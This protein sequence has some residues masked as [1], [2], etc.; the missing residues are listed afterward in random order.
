MSMSIFSRSS[1]FR[2][3][4]RRGQFY[5]IEA[6]LKVQADGQTGGQLVGSS[7]KL[8][9]AL[10][11]YNLAYRALCGILF[12][13]VPKSGHPGGSIS[14]GHIIAGLLFNTMD[15][16]IGDPGRKDADHLCFAAGHKAMGL[17]AAWALRNECVRISMK[18]LLPVSENQQL[19]L[20]DLLGFRRNPASKTPLFKKYNSK[21][22]D[23]HPSPVTP[24]VRL[25]TGASGVGVTTAVGMALGVLD[26]YYTSGSSSFAVPIIH[27]LEGEGGLTPGRVQE[28]MAAA[29]SAQLKNIIMHIDWN[30]ASIDSNR[31]C[32]EGDLA[33]DYV[34][35]SPLELCYMHDWNVIWVGN[36]FD[37][38]QVL[39]AQ[40]LAKEL[41]L[42][43]GN[44][45]PTAIVYRTIKGWRYGIEGKAAHGA[46]HEFCSAAFY[47]SLTEFEQSFKVKFPCL[48]NGDADRSCHE[49]SAGDTPEVLL[50]RNFFDCLLTVR[51]ALEQSK[52]CIAVPLVQQMLMA[53]GRLET[54]HCTPRENAPCIDAIYCDD[55]IKITETPTELKLT[56]GK[57]TT[58]RGILSDCLGYLNRK[59]RG[60]IIGSSADLFG[61]TSVTNLSQG[62]AEG[63]YNFERNP[64]GRLFRSGGICEDAIGGIMA[65]VSSFGQHMGVGSS[66]AAFVVAMQ[67]VAVRLYA[68]GQEA[69]RYASGEPCNP[70]LMICAH[71]GPKTGEDGPTHA[72]SQAL[73]LLSENF[74]R[75]LVITLTPSEPQ[76]IWPLLIASLRIRPAVIAPFVSRPSEKVIDRAAYKLPPA[77]L[78]AQGV[79]RMRTAQGIAD[80]TLVIQGNG[81]AESFIQ[82]VLPYLDQQ[83]YNLNV[84]YIASAE[85]FDLLLPAEQESIFPSSHAQE[86]MGITEFTLPTMYRWVTSSRGREHTLHCYKRGHYLGS[87]QGQMVLGEAGLDA[88]GQLMAIKDYVGR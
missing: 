28:A 17:Y 5:D 35:W 27:I 55:S 68:I 3:S 12:N 6:I 49:N 47:K 66:Y 44:N 16:D 76:E 23:G 58:L 1:P 41:A 77:H 11:A 78:A 73:Q 42:T 88:Q 69:R 7:E 39:A 67:H 50:E 84:Y 19:R 51:E 75:G 13:F 33:G 22:L 30:Q 86:A 64:Q 43:H 82:E 34:Q 57:S 32:R 8:T 20:E 40:S 71:A 46:G 54:K 70:Y 53:R 9:D 31:V 72:D 38:A 59:S 87:G 80:G 18:E 15:Y 14:S 26:Y 29:A 65:G 61:S 62:V 56:A 81:V 21:A 37:F 85:L 10:S 2:C 48:A 60:A 63:F 79:Y 45:Q 25:S 74:P 52:D 4:Q 36:G 83:G 24:F